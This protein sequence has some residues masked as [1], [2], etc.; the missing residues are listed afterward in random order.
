MAASIAAR[1]LARPRVRRAAHSTLAAVAVAALVLASPSAA[2]PTVPAVGPVGPLGFPIWIHDA[3]GLQV[4]PC[5][6]PADP[7][8]PAPIGIPHPSAPLSIPDNFPD[9]FFY[10]TT[11]ASAGPASLTL[12]LEGA[13][14]SV[15]G[16]PEANQQ[17]LFARTRV[18]AQHLV[19]GATY[20]VTLPL[21]EPLEITADA[22]GQLRFTEDIGAIPGQFEG[23]WAGRITHLLVAA[24][25]MAPG[26]L[27]NS[28]TESP[29]TGSPT[30][31]N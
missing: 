17:I 16:G 24:G 25:A 7:F 8:C 6:D 2:D 4:E 31:R 26:H 18:R 23:A 13:F 3:S 9:E 21:G 27:G 28:S 1:P 30:G 22:I 29:V 19:A 12:A 14:A 15:T 5:L 10:W 11:A 20:T